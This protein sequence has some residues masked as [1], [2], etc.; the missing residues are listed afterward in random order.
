MPPAEISYELAPTLS[1]DALNSL[2]AD[3]WPHHERSHF[4]PMLARS[5]TYV[6]ACADRRL[7]GFV[8]VAWDGGQHAFLLD[9]TVHPDYRRRGIGTALVQRAAAAAR[10]CGAAWLHVDYEPHLATFYQACGFRSTLAG[11]IRL[12]GP[13]A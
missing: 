4:A 8:N 3:A 6:A 9:T 7:I 1:D 13:S 5:L 12:D 10:A 2:F 11:L